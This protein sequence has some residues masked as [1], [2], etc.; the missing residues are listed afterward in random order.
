MFSFCSS[1]SGCGGITGDWHQH[2]MDMFAR[3]EDRPNCCCDGVI[4][5]LIK[6]HLEG[7]PQKLKSHEIQ[8]NNLYC[9]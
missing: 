5:T 7:D 4:L 1:S 9:Y 3:N 6:L 8:S 2:L